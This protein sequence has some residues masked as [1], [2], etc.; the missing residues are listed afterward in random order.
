MT[1]E[2]TSIL[3]AVKLLHDDPDRER[4]RTNAEEDKLF[5]A[6]IRATAGPVTQPV[7]R[8]HPD[9]ALREADPPHYMIIL[10]HR[11]KQIEGK[12]PNWMPAIVE[13]SGRV[14]LPTTED[15]GDD[16]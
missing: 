8:P 9:K 10:G 16:N 2:P 15:E 6:S 4:K 14:K 1:Q 13:Y 3:V 11:R 5:L 7:I 12:A